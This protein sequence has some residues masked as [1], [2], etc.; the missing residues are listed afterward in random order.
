MQKIN[1]KHLLA[2]C[3][4]KKEKHLEMVLVVQGTWMKLSG[5]VCLV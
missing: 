5:W 4:L 1:N 2:G 3:Y